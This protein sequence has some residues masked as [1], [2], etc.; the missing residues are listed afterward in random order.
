MKK[1][2]K[3]KEKKGVRL[4]IRFN[5]KKVL[6]KEIRL[7]SKVPEALDKKIEEMLKNGAERA[8][9]NNRTTILAQDL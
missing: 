2:T 7:G 1:K 4:A 6:P 3:N 5:I 9:A 8:K